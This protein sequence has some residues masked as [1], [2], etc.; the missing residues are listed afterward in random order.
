MQVQKQ[1]SIAS[2][3][4][5]PHRRSGKILVLFAVLLPVLL[6]VA[7]LVIDG[8]LLM[9][10]HRGAQHVADAAATAAARMLQ[11]GKSSSVARQRAEDI[12]QQYN[13]LAEATVV[14]N[15]PPTS[16]GYTGNSNFVEVQIT[17][18]TTTHFVNFVGGGSSQVRSRAVAGYEASTAGAA[19][20]V[21]DP[22]PAPLSVAGVLTLPALP[23]LL[24]GLEV[25]GAG[26]LQVDGAVIVNTEWGG[27]DEDNNRA[28][29]RPSPP[30][31]VSC[32]PVLALTKLR[33]RDLRVVGGVD[34]PDN[35]GNF[36]SGERSPLQ[37]NSLPYPDPLADLPVPTT[38]VDS[39]NVNATNRGG[40]RIIGLPIGPWQVMNP[41][42]YDWIE[43]VSGRVRMNPGVYIIRGRN[44][45][46]QISL[47]V[48]AGQ[49]SAEGVM[50]YITNSAGYTPGSGSP[51]NSD[52]E[53]VPATPGLGSLL[54]SVVLNVGLLGSQ[55][56][57]LDDPTSPFDGMTIYQR[58]QDRR[59]I[60][61]LNDD[62]LGTGEFSGRIYG[63]WAHVILA[64]RGTFDATFVAGTMRI[65]AV[66]DAVVDPSNLLPPAEDVFLVE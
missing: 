48:L 19:I 60:I 17:Q 26:R 29:D 4:A 35:Y 1:I 2:A 24:G 28:G 20:A 38:T 5:T 12:V 22:D 58:R 13:D 64:G 21:L 31:G 50:F 30:S 66:L 41:G 10:E 9:S 23:T 44:P 59:P 32:T 25:L 52:G 11:L 45:L 40:V 14:I 16:G 43:I 37:A 46:T 15:I 27:Y 33:A 47:N 49:V 3:V 57:P 65:L 18:P 56:T 39:A 54:P 51:D 55:F 6:G 36:T 53:T 8:S 63:K 34:D 61:V 7:G 42:V 62:L